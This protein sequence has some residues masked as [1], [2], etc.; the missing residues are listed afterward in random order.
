MFLSLINVQYRVPVLEKYLYLK[1]IAVGSWR[2]PQR[3][4]TLHWLSNLM[5]INFLMWMHLGMMKLIGR[6]QFNPNKLKG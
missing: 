4:Q 2:Q 3:C 1:R 6:G 5:N